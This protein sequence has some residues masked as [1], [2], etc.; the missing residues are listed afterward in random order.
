MEKVEKSNLD[1]KPEEVLI[2]DQF[3]LNAKKKLGSGAFGEI[4]YGSDIARK[5]E[6]AIK[7]ERLDAQFPQLLREAKIYVALQ[8]GSK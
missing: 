2:G 7:L 3:I 8:G 5:T 1:L 4:Y 6:V